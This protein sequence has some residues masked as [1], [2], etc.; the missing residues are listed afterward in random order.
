LYNQLKAEYDNSG[1][2]DFLRNKVDAAALERVKYR[3]SLVPEWAREA[4][5]LARHRI[6]GLRGMLPSWAH[7]ALDA[8]E[9]VAKRH[10]DP[11]F[12]ERESFTDGKPGA[13][14]MNVAQ[15]I[16]AIH[17]MRKAARCWSGYEAVPGAK[18]YSRGSC[19]P[20]GSKKTQKEMKK[21]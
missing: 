7:D 12:A 11:L 19:R 2:P 16:I 20:V 10:V 14:D 8:P 15:K 4:G 6:P 9:V 17:T 3:Q 13:S 21:S 5:Q 18:A 1:K